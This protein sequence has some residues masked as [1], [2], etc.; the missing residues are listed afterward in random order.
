MSQQQVANPAEVYEQF[1]VPTFFIPWTP[2]LL[3]YARP[4]L[5]ERVLDLACGTGIVARHVAPIVGANGKVTALDVSPAMLEVARNLPAPVGALIEWREGNAV[6][7]PLADGAFDLVLCQQGFQ[8]FADRAAAA[9]EMRRV[10]APSGRVALSVWQALDHHP[11]Y[12]ALF[13]A[14]ARQLDAPVAALAMAFS[15]G[16]AEE[17]RALLSAAGLSEVGITPES[18]TIRFPSL[19]RFLSLSVRSA[20]AIIPAFAQLDE[21]AR[22]VLVEAVGGEI[23]GNTALRRYIEG[24]VVVIPMSAHV[25]VAHA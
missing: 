14:M 5:G 16:D 23:K 17:M 1:I 12:L 22:S 15:F 3:K 4:R 25:A 21:P 11:F 13:E 19:D 10:L 7:L 18:L 8:F 6:D 24:D 20:A 9:R 2:V